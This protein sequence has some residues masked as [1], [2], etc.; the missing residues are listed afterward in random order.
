MPTVLVTGGSGYIGSHTCLSLLEYGF[1]VISIDSNINSQKESLDKVFEIFKSSKQNSKNQLFFVEGDMRDEKLLDKIFKKAISEKMPIEAVLHLAGLKSVG[2]STKN[3][4]EYWDVNVGGSICLF[5]CMQNNN[6]NTIVFSSSA[7]IYGECQEGSL[8]T[9]ESPIKPINPYGEN[10]VVIEK[11]LK[12]I[13]NSS[14]EKWKIA[15]LRYFNPIGAHATGLIGEEPKGIPNNIFPYICQVALGKIDKLEIFGNN[16][17]TKDGT[18]IRDYIH[19]M[20]LAHAHTCALNHLTNKN[21]Q[22]LN[23]NIGTGIS[24]SVLELVETFIEVNS[25]K[26]NYVF[27]DRRLGDSGYVVAD[28]KLALRTI[29]WAPKKNIKDMCKDGWRYVSSLNK[30]IRKESNK[31]NL[32]SFL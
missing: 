24:T 1:D 20:D 15:N 3:P 9:E 31:T 13:F 8:I 18:C 26:V 30:K 12:N 21:S 32:K 25:C 27:G 11:I 14:K 10:K 19:I 2:E 7:T 28:N 16:W 29:D 23:L 4:V 22:F 5:K 6:C 17:P